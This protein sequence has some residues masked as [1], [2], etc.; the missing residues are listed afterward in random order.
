MTK[1]PTKD[2]KD[3]QFRHNKLVSD[4]RFLWV[5][6]ASIEPNELKHIGM[7]ASVTLMPD[8][9]PSDNRPMPLKERYIQAVVVI[10]FIDMNMIQ[11]QGHKIMDI[12]FENKKYRRCKF[13]PKAKN[14]FSPR[15]Q[16]NAVVNCTQGGESAQ[17]IY[18]QC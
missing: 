4:P 5:L 2:T 13:E 7:W 3:S 9:P 6:E 16:W 11:K 14:Y 12:Y 1:I 10:S 17:A 15:A 8:R 18:V